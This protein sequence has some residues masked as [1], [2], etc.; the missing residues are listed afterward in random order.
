MTPATISSN[1]GSKLGLKFFNG[2]IAPILNCFISITSLVLGL[3]G[4]TPTQGCLTKSSCST[5]LLTEPLNLV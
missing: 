4:K 2:S 1:Q 5:V 3:Y